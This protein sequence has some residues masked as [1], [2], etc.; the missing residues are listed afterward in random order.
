ML[1]DPVT[2]ANLTI[3]EIQSMTDK[4]IKANGNYLHKYI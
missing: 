2:A 3:D 1:L 4:L